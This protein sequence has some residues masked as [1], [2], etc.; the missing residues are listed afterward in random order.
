MPLRLRFLL[1]QFFYASQHLVLGQRGGVDH[2]GVGGGHKRRG[3]AGPIAVVAFPQVRG[4]AG[5]HFALDFLLGHAAL[6][7]DDWVGIEKNFQIGVG[8]NLRADVAAFHDDAAART[9]F[10]LASDHPLANF[11]MH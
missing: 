7:T 10:A 8:K 4:Y 6:L 3:G 2:N 11:G 1:H 9:H 5:C